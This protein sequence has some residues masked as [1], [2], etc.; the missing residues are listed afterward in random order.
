MSSD[1]F[2][3]TTSHRSVTWI[4]LLRGINVGGANRLPMA[5]L[6]S[7]FEAVGC[8]GVE[9]LL[10][11]GNAVVDHQDT[12]EA[13]LAAAVSTEL[14]CRFG[15]D[16]PVI[17]RPGDDLVGLAE[18]HPDIHGGIEPKFLHVVLFDRVP[19]TTAADRLDLTRFEPDRA[20][21]EGRDMFVTYPEG[22]GRSKLTI[23]VFERGLG[24]VATARNVNTVQKLAD[25]VA[26]R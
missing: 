11:S 1:G 6:R 24:V 5:D 10:Q 18:R 26:A 20:V 17:V 19:A 14:E 8:T 9:T 4:V 3:A 23:D 21:L 15:I 16:V 2:A 22:S 12:T 13:E 7:V 25:R